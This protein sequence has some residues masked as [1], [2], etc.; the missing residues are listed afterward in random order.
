MGASPRNT[1]T[2]QRRSFENPMVKRLDA[3]P[4]RR[5]ALRA[6][7]EPL[8]PRSVRR[9]FGARRI[10]SARSAGTP[11][12]RS[13]LRRTSASVRIMVPPRLARKRLL[14]DTVL[15]P[16]RISGRSRRTESS[17][18]V[19][20]AWQVKTPSLLDLARRPERLFTPHRRLAF[21][22]EG[23][24]GPHSFPIR[25]SNGGLEGRNVGRRRGW[26]RRAR[27]RWHGPA[28][29]SRARMTIRLGLGMPRAGRRCLVRAGSKRSMKRRARLHPSPV[30]TMP[31]RLPMYG[32]GPA[33]VEVGPGVRSSNQRRR[34]YDAG[35]CQESVSSESR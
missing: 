18:L 27:T 16:P 31:R 17:R 33:N 14:I 11:K 15:F 1:R 34:C 7:S 28:G 12:A 23:H 10:R 9:R 6:Q 4:R 29:P 32:P 25:T 21:A 5:S 13:T 24:A 2:W 19:G 3:A 8:A 30:Q 26:C 20:I 22:K 35:A